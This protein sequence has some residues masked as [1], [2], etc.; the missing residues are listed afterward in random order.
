[1]TWLVVVIIA[2]VVII[3]ITGRQP[4]LCMEQ[5]NNTMKINILKD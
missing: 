3:T 4:V 2:I 1:M 5:L